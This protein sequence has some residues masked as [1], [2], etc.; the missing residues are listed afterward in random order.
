MSNNGSIITVKIGNNDFVIIGN[1]NVITDV[2]ISNN[3]V[4]V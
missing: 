3:C 4:I 2:I 1:N